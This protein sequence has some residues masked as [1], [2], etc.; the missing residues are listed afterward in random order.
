M[1]VGDIVSIFSNAAA[2]LYTVESIPNATQ[3]IVVE[4][5]PNSIGGGADF[6]YP[7]GATKVGFNPNNTQNITAN[8]VQEAIEQLDGYALTEQE[9][10][11][12]DTIAHDIVEDSYTVASYLGPAGRLSNVTTYTDITLTTKIREQEYTYIGPRVNQ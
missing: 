6:I 5:I 8:T 9:H 7:A 1:E 12:L 3:F 2:G 11:F 10:E 4:N